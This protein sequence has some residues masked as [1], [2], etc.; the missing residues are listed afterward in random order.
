MAITIRLAV[1]EPPQTPAI[2]LIRIGFAMQQA[3]RLR[4]E[5]EK[6]NRI[7]VVSIIN[8]AGTARS[9]SIG[10]NRKSRAVGFLAYGTNNL[11]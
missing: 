2:P 1:G 6:K 4:I 8:L 3:L 10:Q 9:E 7:Y 5:K 11:S